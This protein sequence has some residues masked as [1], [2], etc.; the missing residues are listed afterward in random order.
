M[1][2]GDFMKKKLI[3]KT[4][5]EV[6]I[7]TDP[8]RVDIIQV[9]RKNDNKPLTVKDIA[10]ALGEPHGKVYYHIKKFEKIGAIKLDHTENIKGITAKYYILDFSEIAIE[11]KCKS[12]MSEDVE[13]NHTLN[14]ISKFYDDSK[15][16]FVN[17]VKK[18]KEYKSKEDLKEGEKTSH[19]TSNNLYF[20]KDS[21]EEFLKEIDILIEKYK[22]ETKAANEF[23]KTIFLSV[24]SEL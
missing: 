17:Y 21:Y 20:T 6:R 15:N 23:K 13:L 5:E 8:Y 2:S 24:Y 16:A 10:N 7:M 11:Y 3:L 19:L 18:V 22:I 14:M 4:K 1:I 12:D 9:F